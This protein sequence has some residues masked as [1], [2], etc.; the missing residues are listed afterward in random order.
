MFALL[1]AL[2]LYWFIDVVMVTC[3]LCIQGARGAIGAPGRQGKM[4]SKGGQGIIGAPGSQGGPGPTVRTLSHPPTHH[5]WISY[6]H[7][8]L[9]MHYCK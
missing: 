9:L 7:C 8:L 2:L 5:Y 1:V 4:G 3:V 6:N